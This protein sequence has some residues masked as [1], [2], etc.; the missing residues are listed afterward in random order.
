MSR[1]SDHQFS[2][3][4]RR[5][6]HRRGAGRRAQNKRAPAAA[7]AS[8]FGPGRPLRQHHE[9]HPKRAAQSAQGILPGTHQQKRSIK[10]ERISSLFLFPLYLQRGNRLS[11]LYSHPKPGDVYKRQKKRSGLGKLPPSILGRA[12]ILPCR[13]RAS[14]GDGSRQ[15]TPRPRKGCALPFRPCVYYTLFLAGV[16]L[17]GYRPSSS[18]I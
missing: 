2:E 17:R 1:R 9:K 11:Y 15:E 16:Q 3:G 10:K 7:H 6:H 18:S 12:F 4:A 14:C 5:G 8:A 13:R